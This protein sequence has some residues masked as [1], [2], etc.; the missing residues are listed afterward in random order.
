VT[1]EEAPRSRA[2][3]TDVWS[4]PGAPS[5]PGGGPAWPPSQVPQAAVTDRSADVNLDPTG[6]RRVAR[7][8]GFAGPSVFVVA[9][10]ALHGLRAD[11]DPTAHTISEYSLGSYGWLMRCAFGALGLGVL[12][13]VTSL[14]T[15]LAASLWRVSGLAL[16][17]ATAVGLFLDATY[18]TDHPHVM[19]TADG[20]VHAFGTWVI[21]LSLPAAVVILSIAVAD[22]GM[23]APARWLRVLAAAEI[24]ATLGYEMGPVDYRGVAE[25]VVSVFA[26]AGIVLLQSLTVRTAPAPRRATAFDPARFDSGRF[27]PALFDSGRFD[28]G[29]FDAGRSDSGRFDSG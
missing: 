29:R 22:A 2:T 12:A 14:R 5:P 17:S 23:S 9:I 25:R 11:L 20:A 19:E 3:G 7:I 13:T 1:D 8:V 28:A 24:V 16:L 4:R 6:W 21:T 26:V 27:D 10:A 15:S 18:N